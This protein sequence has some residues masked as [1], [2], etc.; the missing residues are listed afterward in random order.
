[1]TRGAGTCRAPAATLRNQRSPRAEVA[2][3][4][5]AQRRA[6]TP[7][8]GARATGPPD[9]S[10]RGTQRWRTP[11]RPGHRRRHAPVPGGAARPSSSIS[12]RTALGARRTND[13][14]PMSPPPPR[15]GSPGARRGP[16]HRSANQPRSA[17]AGRT[18]Q[19]RCR[20]HR[21]APVPRGRGAAQL[22]GQPTNRARHQADERRKADVP[23]TAGHRPRHT[24][25]PGSAAQP[26]SSISQR[27][28]LGTRRTNDARPMSPQPPDTGRATRRFPGAQRSPAHRSANEPRS[29]P[30]GRTTQGRCR[31]HRRAP[32]PRGAARPSSS[33]SR[34][35]VVGAGRVNEARPMS[36]PP[37]RTGGAVPFSPL[38]R[39]DGARGARR[40]RP[41]GPPRGRPRGP[42]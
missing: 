4:H 37:P 8:R 11:G 17:P 6:A 12:Q 18:R 31:R 23:A 13:A 27:T 19:G 15:A 3:K 29:A 39:P 34:R 25:V 2:I 30:G 5:L 36:P 41:P 14:R 22:I 20:R 10:P 35:T 24:P 38:R 42:P 32:V 33:V 40:P 1:M 26:S 9:G 16:A 28:A 21:R 7:V